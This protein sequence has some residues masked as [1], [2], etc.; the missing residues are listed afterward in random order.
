MPQELIATHTPTSYLGSTVCIVRISCIRGAATTSTINKAMAIRS[1]LTSSSG[2][3]PLVFKF[4]QCVLPFT[5]VGFQPASDKWEQPH[6][7]LINDVDNHT[8]TDI[9]ILCF[10]VA[11]PVNN[12]SGT[13]DYGEQQTMVLLTLMECSLSMP[14]STPWP[15]TSPSVF[16]DAQMS[17]LIPTKSRS[18]CAT[19]H[20][21]PCIIEV[22]RYYVIFYKTMHQRTAMI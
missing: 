18:H 19:F 5:R 4:L 20:R 8:D 16:F 7:C 2:V 12:S 14:P 1:A 11:F 9:N 15:T 6:L 3:R 17:I 10:D 21:D 13:N 22:V